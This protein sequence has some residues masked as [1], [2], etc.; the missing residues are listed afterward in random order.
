MTPLVSVLMV[1]HNH[2]NFIKGAIESVLMQ[3]APFGIEIVIGEDASTDG[4]AE[5]IRKYSSAHPD[6]IFATHHQVNLGMVKNFFHT[7]QRCRGEYIALLDGDDRWIRKDKLRLQVSFLQQHP[8]VVICGGKTFSE[9]KSSRKGYRLAKWIKAFSQKKVETFGRAEMIISNRLHTLTVMGR[10]ECFRKAET[11]I[12]ECPVLDWPFFV[13]LS[14]A[15]SELKYVNLPFTFA[16]YNVHSGGV[17]SGS[18][19]LSRLRISASARET[20]TSLTRG[21]YIGWHFP[22]CYL[23]SPEDYGD[24]FL[25]LRYRNAFPDAAVLFSGND[26]MAVA[27][28]VLAG[29]E[30]L[31]EY[32]GFIF[33]K[34]FQCSDNFDAFTTKVSALMRKVLRSSLTGSEKSELLG[35]IGTAWRDTLFYSRI[36]LKTLRYFLASPL[37]KYAG[38]YSYTVVLV[39]RQSHIHK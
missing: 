35:S 13:N 20:I 17:F 32:F 11:G 25:E 38:I 23:S 33:G 18:N 9:N 1:T 30:Y 26:L 12:S 39:Y 6:K 36:G 7:L 8:E 31:P 2:A 28:K 14:A 29:S 19:L 3:D 15:K 24:G 5:I 37:R 16:A 27:E 21:R 10:A 22:V 34:L 4:T